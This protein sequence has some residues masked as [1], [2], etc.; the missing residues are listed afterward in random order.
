[1]GRTESL[2]GSVR[3][4]TVASLEAPGADRETGAGKRTANPLHVSFVR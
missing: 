2:L 3:E 1:M 4:R